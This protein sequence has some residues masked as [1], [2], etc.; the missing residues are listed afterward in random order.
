MYA[1]NSKTGSQIKGTLERLHGCALLAG[2]GFELGE[3]GEI[4][5]EHD[6]DTDVYWDDSKT[7]QQDGQDVFIDYNGD[8]VTADHV[9]LVEEPPGE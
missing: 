1:I 7:V 4:R 5:F 8:L 6:G 2:E 3:D 9:R